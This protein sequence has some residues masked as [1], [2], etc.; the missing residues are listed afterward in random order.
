M[1]TNQK[2][3]MNI[4]SLVVPCWHKCN[5]HHHYQ[6]LV[7]TILAS[8]TWILFR[9]HSSLQWAIYPRIDSTF[10]NPSFVFPSISIPA[11]TFP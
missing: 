1:T 8:T 4:Q 5:H 6:S 3:K 9:R 10:S 11:D 7:L 2:N